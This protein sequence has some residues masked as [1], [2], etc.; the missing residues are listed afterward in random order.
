VADSATMQT[1]RLTLV[2]TTIEHLQAELHTPERFPT[3]LGAVVPASWPPGL[4]DRDAMEYFLDRLQQEGAGAVG[5]YGWYAV[6]RA[7]GTEPATLVASGGYFGPPTANGTVEIGYSVVPEYRRKG[8]ATELVEALTGRALGL[9]FVRRVV[10]EAHADNTASLAVLARCGFRNV[11]AG[12]EPGR[13][14]FAR[15]TA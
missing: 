4:Y 3:L 6:L 11:G 2:A 8:Y 5:W 1:P 12:R 13:L 14:R 7:N 9:P 15:D 10:A